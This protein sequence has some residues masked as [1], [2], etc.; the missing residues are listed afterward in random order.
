MNS[1]AAALIACESLLDPLLEQLITV[2]DEHSGNFAGPV[3]EA[4]ERLR[5][6]RRRRQRHDLG[7]H[8]RDARTNTT[9]APLGSRCTLPP[10]LTELMAAGFRKGSYERR[11][12]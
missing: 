8:P 6:N 7:R 1:S 3:A 10:L 5:A 12:Q 4:L 11:D 9:R 2:L